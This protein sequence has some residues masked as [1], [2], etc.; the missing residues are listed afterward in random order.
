[1]SGQTRPR[2]QTK[3]QPQPVVIWRQG[4]H[5]VGSALWC[6]ALRAQ[7]LCFV[8]SALALHKSRRR[9]GTLLTTLTTMSLL[10]A[11]QRAPS[12]AQL[13]SPLGRP[14]YWGSL[15]LELFANGDLPGS[16]SLWVKLPSEERVVFAGQPSQT[17]SPLVEPMQL[18]P[19]ETLVMAAPFASLLANMPSLQALAEQVMGELAAA[20]GQGVPLLIRCSSVT[21]LAELAQRL[22]QGRLKLAPELHRALVGC[23]TLPHFPT[24]VSGAS[25]TPRPGQ[26]LWWP[27]EAALPSSPWK[28]RELVIPD[29]LGL[30]EL[31]AYARGSGA[32]RVYLTAGYSESVAHALAPHRISAAPLGPPEQLGLF[33]EAAPP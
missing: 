28:P 10:S 31:V 24:L 29:G 20:H 32:Q 15:R 19:A 1:M 23:Q 26:V 17:P 11:L 8:S 6:D 16:A 25:R 3:K 14:F 13:L 7:E 2:K 21:K 22:D 27:L 4:I 9:A 33:G 12:G 5:L 30:A 18:R